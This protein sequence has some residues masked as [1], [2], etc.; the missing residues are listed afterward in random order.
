MTTKST[1]TKERHYWEDYIKREA[2]RAGIDT[3]GMVG[4]AIL[5][6]MVD[7]ITHLKAVLED[8]D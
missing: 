6:E 5:H 8:E 7:Q 4:G 1:I 2:D 3:R